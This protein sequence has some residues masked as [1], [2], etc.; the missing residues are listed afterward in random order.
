[1][2]TATFGFFGGTPS[3]ETLRREA[4]RLCPMGYEKTGERA[5]VF[6]GKFVEWEIRCAGAS[7][8]HSKSSG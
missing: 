2:A 1:M 5:G 4:S 8:T 3:T 6:E 7:D